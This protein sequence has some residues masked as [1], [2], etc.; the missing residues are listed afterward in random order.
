MQPPPLPFPWAPTVYSQI[1]SL[2]RAGVWWGGSPSELQG[3]PA[4]QTR[5]S[6]RSLPRAWLLPD[7][8]DPEPILCIAYPMQVWYQ[9]PHITMETR[10]SASIPE[11]IC[12]AMRRIEFQGGVHRRAKRRHSQ[13]LWGEGQRR[14]GGDRLLYEGYRSNLHPVKRRSFL[15]RPG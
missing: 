11:L 9:P 7:S 14:Q 4:T 1:R 3:G 12:E 10:A 13:K 5:L 6:H 2:R 15:D 8:F